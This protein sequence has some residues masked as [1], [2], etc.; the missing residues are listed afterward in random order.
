MKDNEKLVQGARG[1]SFDEYDKVMSEY[2]DK[3]STLSGKEWD[4]LYKEISKFQ[5]DYME[6]V[7]EE[8]E[9]TID[10]EAREYIYDLLC[11]AVRVSESGSSIVYVETEELADGIEDII[12]QE[13]WDYLLDYEIYQEDNHWVVDCIFGGNYVPYWDGWNKE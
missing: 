9:K 3:L 6:G 13:M 5:Q 10:C 8:Y 4:A 12:W 1:I 2:A 11:H 7:L